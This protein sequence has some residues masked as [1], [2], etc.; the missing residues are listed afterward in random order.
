[1]ADTENWL[2]F[3][4]FLGFARAKLPMDVPQTQ[5]KNNNTFCRR[6]NNNHAP[7]IPPQTCLVKRDLMRALS[8]LVFPLPL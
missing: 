7:H 6:S 4:P 1:M 2:S 3:P 8:P 5:Y